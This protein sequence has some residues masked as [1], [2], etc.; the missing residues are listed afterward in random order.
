MQTATP[1]S[2]THSRQDKDAKEELRR[3]WDGS[4]GLECL[5]QEGWETGT[6]LEGPALPEAAASWSQRSQTHW[7]DCPGHSK[8]I[9]AIK[10]LI[11]WNVLVWHLT[12]RLDN[13]K[14]VSDRQTRKHIFLLLS[15]DNLTPSFSYCPGTTTPALTLPDQNFFLWLNIVP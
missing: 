10:Q 12:G 14:P 3:K 4:G 13:P 2:I 1:I 8:K 11:K 7:T 9:K 15:L 5:W 6:D